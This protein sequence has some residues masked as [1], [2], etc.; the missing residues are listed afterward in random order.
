MLLKGL[1]KSKEWKIFNDYLKELIL[2]YLNT[3]ESK[4]FLRGLR[5]AVSKFEEEIE[6][7]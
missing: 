1:I 3:T 6:R 5:F 7:I 4:D 2:I